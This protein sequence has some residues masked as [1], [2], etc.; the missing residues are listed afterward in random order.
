MFERIVVP[1]DGSRFS[2]T[3][4]SYAI[5]IAKQFGSEVTLVHVVIPSNPMIWA[6]PSGVASPTATEIAIE[7]AQLRDKENAQRATRYLKRKLRQLA[8]Q[9]VKTSFRVSIGS[10]AK[11]IIE[12]CEK[13]K[14]N[15]VVMTTSGRSG[16]KRAIL[17]S[18]ADELIR[19][20]GIP[21]LAI[22]PRKRGKK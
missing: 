20:P 17:G 10:P 22:R 13:E 9:G 11:S 15:L 2:A 4:L 7:A 12:F 6:S 8:A 14:V 18:V 1:L 19:E 21:V 16:I 3:A 5:E